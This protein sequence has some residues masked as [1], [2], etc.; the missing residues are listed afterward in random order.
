MV[1]LLVVRALLED[2]AWETGRSQATAPSY[3]HEC[4]VGYRAPPVMVSTK[5]FAP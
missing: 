1:G 5:R 4:I 3:A 2:S